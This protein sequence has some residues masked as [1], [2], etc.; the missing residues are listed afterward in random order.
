M[1]LR[2]RRASRRD[3]GDRWSAAYASFML[4][5]LAPDRLRACALYEDS[6][7]AFSALGDEH[8][9]LLAT[10]HLAFAHEAL[11][12]PAEARALHEQNLARARSTGNQRMEASSLGALAD[13]AMEEERV[14]HAIALL[15]HSLRIHRELGDVLDTGVD[16]CRLA[17]GSGRRTGGLVIRGAITGSP[18][19]K[20]LLNSSKSF[21]PIRGQAS[22]AATSY[23]NKLRGRSEVF[24]ADPCSA[25]T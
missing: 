12:E 14:D 1:P 8:S 23:S 9:A 13:Y 7:R 21:T 10:R 6:I 22:L 20:R 2:R 3:L 25:R 16:L 15:R 19:S 18:H 24:M 11:G 17:G 5:N 4:G